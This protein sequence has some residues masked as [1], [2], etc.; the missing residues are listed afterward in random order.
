MQ[1]M[2]ENMDTNQKI[3]HQLRRMGFAT[4]HMTEERGGQ[5]RILM[6]LQRRGPMTQRELT[7]I[8]GVQSG[9]ASEI[10]SKIEAAGLIERS[11]NA[12]DQR[13]MDVRLTEAGAAAAAAAREENEARIREMFSALTEEEKE[14]LSALLAKV[15]E[16]WRER[17]PHRPRR[18]H[19]RPGEGPGRR[20]PRY[21]EDD[22]GFHGRRHGEDGEGF[23]GPRHSEDGEGFHGRRHSEDGEGFRGRRHG[24]DGEGFH[25]HRH[26]E[27][28]EGFRGPHGGDG[29]ADP[30]R[31]PC[32]GRH[33]PKDALSCPRGEAYFAQKEQE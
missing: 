27:D 14:Q 5:K 2:H 24:E 22:E 6:M 25:G 29:D 30:D 20:G 11:P 18:P 21:G 1:K 32:C 9:S 16:D 33:C 4:Q 17:F 7:E 23:R 13:T 31:C 19:G 26:S 8:L 12:E 10:L 15:D 3:Y 28:E